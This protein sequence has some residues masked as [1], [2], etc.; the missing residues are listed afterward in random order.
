M[1]ITLGDEE[2]ICFMDLY[3]LLLHL[4]EETKPLTLP[5]SRPVYFPQF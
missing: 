1:D 3:L 5:E 2:N 4:P